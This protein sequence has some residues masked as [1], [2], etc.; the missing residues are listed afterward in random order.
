M[1]RKAMA[2]CAL[3]LI[4]FVMIQAGCKP[5]TYYLERTYKVHG[6]VTEAETSPPVALVSVEVFVGE[7]QY[8]ELTNY[9]GDYEMELPAGTWTIRFV[10][11]GYETVEAQVT[12]GPDSPRVQ[13]DMRMTRIVTPPPEINLTG[14]WDF[15]R[16]EDGEV[17]GP[18]LDCI[19]QEGSSLKMRW[20]SGTITGSDVVLGG[21][22]EDWDIFYYV[23][24][25][26]TV[27]ADGNKLEGTGTIDGI[28]VLEN[29]TMIRPSTM[30]FGD[31]DVLGTFDGLPQL[32]VNDNHAIGSGVGDMGDRFQ[33][34]YLN[35][36]FDVQLVFYFGDFTIGEPLSA[37]ITIDKWTI[38]EDGV[39]EQ[40]LIDEMGS[41][42]ATLTLY[43]FDGIR[44]WGEFTATYPNGTLSGSF[45]VP[46]MD[47]EF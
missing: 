31:L 43:T 2:I 11:A 25:V 22:L 4:A 34:M 24:L 37:G 32:A 27:S 14:Y 28:P 6:T 10:K 15:Y 30:S 3:V 19:L 8:S 17:H 36:E 29:F 39:P 41:T 46:L 7:Y 20:L 13:L 42:S 40:K 18:D 44:A 47:I 35:H 16:T 45:D 12:V 1:T 26:G 38:Y 23:E 21:W 33:I 9:Y 5:V